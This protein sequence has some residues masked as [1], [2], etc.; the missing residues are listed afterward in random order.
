[1][2]KT[3]PED[4]LERDPEFVLMNIRAQFVADIHKAMEFYNLSN[5]RALAKKIGMQQNFL[6]KILNEERTL[7]LKEMIEISVRLGLY[8]NLNM[9]C[10]NRNVVVMSEEDFVEW[11]EKKFGK[12]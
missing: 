9:V 12:R 4:S 11:Q 3:M 5:V 10:P 1:M 2:S 7:D 6:K 8:F